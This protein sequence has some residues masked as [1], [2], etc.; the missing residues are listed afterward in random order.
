MMSFKNRNDYLAKQK[1]D[2]VS[3]HNVY[4]VIRLIMML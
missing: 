3:Y 2:V 4:V 1:S